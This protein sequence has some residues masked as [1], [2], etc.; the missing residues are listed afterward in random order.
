M[1]NKKTKPNTKN[2]EI[3]KANYNRIKDFQM[4]PEG[5]FLIRINKEK[6]QIEAGFCKKN[7]FIEKIIVGRTAMGVFNTIIR[8]GLVSSLQH[9]AD[10]GAELQKAEIALSY[11]LNYVQDGPL[12]IKQ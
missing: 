7:I 8:E 9:A 11:N 10:L 3:I 6:K 5:Y 1:S 12:E 2:A 4:D